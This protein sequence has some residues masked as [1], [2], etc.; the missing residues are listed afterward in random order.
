MTALR[1]LLGQQ[2]PAI[3]DAA[4]TFVGGGGETIRPDAPDGT[5]SAHGRAIAA[6]LA[7]SRLSS[8]GSRIST[9]DVLGMGGMGVV[10]E[11]TQVSLD[12][13]V[14]VKSVRPDKK[15]PGSTLKL[16]QEAW[17]AGR[18]EHPNIVPVYDIG[19]DAQGEPLIVQQRVE[20]WS[21][22]TLC[23][24]ADTV[25]TRFGAS[26]LLDFNVR[27]LMQV[28]NAVHFA[29]SRG[30]VHLDIKPSNVMIGAFGEVLILDWGLAMSLLDDGTGR[31]PLARDNAE[32]IG[33]PSYMAPEMMA[34]DG[35]RLDERTDV[36][37]LG[38]TL[39]ELCCGQPPHTGPGMIATL[40]KIATQAPCP[41]PESPEELGAICVRAMAMDPQERYVS[42][43]ALRLALQDFLE[44]RGS[45]R[46]AEQAC[47]QAALLD[48]ALAQGSSEDVIRGLFSAARFGFEQALHA[49]PHNEVARSRLR[50]L[51]IT[52]CTHALK[53]GNAAHAAEFL[54]EI[55]DP[56][57]ALQEE[58][59]QALEQRAGD[60]VR[61]ADL[62]Q[63]AD[64][65]DLRIGQRTRVFIVGLMGLLWTAAPIARHVGGDVSAEQAVIMM[66]GFPAGF[67]V[68]LGGLLIWARDSMTRTVINRRTGWTA[69]ALLSF[70]IVQTAVGWS[71]HLQH[72][73]IM[74]LNFVL[75]SLCA[76]LYTIAVERRMLPMA[77]GFVLCMALTARWPELVWILTAVANAGLVINAL[78]VW[79]PRPLFP[80]KPPPSAAPT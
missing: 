35:D 57:A 73:Q 67:L 40:Y 30:I 75:W 58:I 28:C 9:R 26:D 4:R 53:N 2:W 63:F 12:R 25:H 11:G 80:P 15:T 70:Q 1:D 79:F 10:H 21:W 60:A 33:T 36:Y 62:Q 68:L 17:I 64:N 47:A 43:E 65:M 18:L 6:L 61:L 22:D 45:I 32:I 19:A 46:L 50:S 55:D 5:D 24:E 41:P 42:A 37:L 76:V 54:A 8:S 13:S 59:A 20:G 14:A 71:M 29:H 56:P 31:L 16:L 34:Q 7:H 27:V 3:E 23:R 69:V 49:W 39:Y 72:L 52:R 77:A 74:T 48:G 44:H 51:Q 38:S 78:V 66:I